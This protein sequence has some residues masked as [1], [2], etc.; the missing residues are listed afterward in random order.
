MSSSLGF[1]LS[2]VYV[3]VMMAYAGDLCRMQ[4]IYA[5]IDEVAATAGKMITRRWKID[6]TVVEFVESHDAHILD[7]NPSGATFSEYS[8][9]SFQIWKTYRPLAFDG[10][11]KKLAVNRTVVLGYRG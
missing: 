7:C 1:M 9:F 6:E 2:L 4:T 3:I 8:N 11:S 10:E 5:E